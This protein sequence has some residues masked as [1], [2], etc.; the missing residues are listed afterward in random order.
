MHSHLLVI[1]VLSGLPLLLGACGGGE[2]GQ[3]DDAVEQSSTTPSASPAS[4]EPTASIA[5][6]TILGGTTSFTT[7]AGD[8][9]D[10]DVAVNGRE[11]TLAELLPLTCRGSTG[12]GGDFVVTVESSLGA[13]TDFTVVVRCGLTPAIPAAS[14]AGGQP[15]LA[16]L[17]LAPY[18][19]VM[20]VTLI[21]ADSAEAALVYQ[22][23]G[24]ECPV[25]WALGKVDRT[26]LFTGGTDALNGEESPIRFRDAAG[27]EACASADGQ[28]GITVSAAQGGRCDR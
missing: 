26:N 23:E 16:D 14:G 4:A 20:G 12:A 25:V 2:A 15:V 9:V 21:G 10:L 28:G 18:G 13:P 27:L 8:A 17:G 11:C 3:A 22:P 19:E 24:A 1:P 6:A 7:D 5:R